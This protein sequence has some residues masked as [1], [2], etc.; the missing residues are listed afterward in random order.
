M[1]LNYGKKHSKLLKKY[2]KEIISALCDGK[3]VGKIS[4]D[5]Q[6]EFG[7]KLTFQAI[8]WFYHNNKEYIDECIKNTE[9]EKK[10]KLREAISFEYAKEQ[11]YLDLSFLELSSSELKNLPVEKKLKYKISLLNALAKMEGKEQSV[12]N[13]NHTLKELNAIFEDDL[14]WE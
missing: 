7:V 1:K 4:E 2:S 13:N 5:L 11:A 8:N 12:I 10:E 9:N 6:E 14:N 3:K